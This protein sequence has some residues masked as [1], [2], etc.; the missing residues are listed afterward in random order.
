MPKKL[1]LALFVAWLVL[2]GLAQAQRSPWGPFSIEGIAQTLSLGQQKSILER[3]CNSQMLKTKWKNLKCNVEGGSLGYTLNTDASAGVGAWIT[4]RIMYG[5]FTR[6]GRAEAIID[7]GFA[8]GDSAQTEA[9]L[10]RR[11]NNVYQPVAWLA[12]DPSTCLG[13][14]GSDQRQRLVCLNSEIEYVNVAIANFTESVLLH[15]IGDTGLKTNTLLQ[16]P[17]TI[18]PSCYTGSNFQLYNLARWSQPNLGGDQRP[19][20]ELEVA[21]ASFGQNVSI[22]K[23]CKTSSQ[24]G[25][26]ELQAE[27]HLPAPKQ[28][29]LQFI[30]NG[31]SF[32]PTPATIAS[33]KR[34]E[35]IK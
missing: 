30:W 14:L 18:L 22:S 5:A 28:N 12:F 17:K 33:K 4:E 35:S 24:T 26:L 2:V 23:L 16:L 25:L 15:D 1:Y 8:L 3:L 32:S 27:L 21:E 6:A 31:S 19:D 7:M 11:V 20:L 29:L 34:L 10:L 13:V 9:V